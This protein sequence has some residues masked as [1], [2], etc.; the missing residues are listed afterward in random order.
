MGN[1]MVEADYNERLLQLEGAIAALQ[2]INGIILNYFG[3][4]LESV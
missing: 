1:D 3:S 2:A 4:V